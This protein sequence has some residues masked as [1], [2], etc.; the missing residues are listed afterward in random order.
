MSENL[1]IISLGGAGGCKI[2]EYLRT[3]NQEAYPYDWIVS[4]QS[5]V[6]N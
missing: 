4:S 2:A 1:K 6:I 5:F 3:K